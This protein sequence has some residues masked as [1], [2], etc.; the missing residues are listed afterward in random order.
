MSPLFGPAPFLHDSFVVVVSWVNSCQKCKL[1]R[2]KFKINS[3]LKSV[4]GSSSENSGDIHWLR[5]VCQLYLLTHRLNVSLNANQLEMSIFPQRNLSPWKITE[6][7]QKIYYCNCLS[8]SCAKYFH[9]WSG[10]ITYSDKFPKVCLIRMGYW[11][12]RSPRS[13]IDSPIIWRKRR[14][15]C[16]ETKC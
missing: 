3:V 5:L 9:N 15:R 12:N 10:T 16:E 6:N 13:R 7:M 14:R 8:I 2:D 11:L 4:K 1:F